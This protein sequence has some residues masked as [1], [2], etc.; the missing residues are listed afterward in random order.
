MNRRE[1]LQK[2]IEMDGA[3]PF[4]HFGLAMEWAKEGQVEES[5]QSFDRCTALDGHYT[6]AFYHKGK[7]LLDAGRLGEARAALKQGIVAA[8]AIANG[9][10]LSEMTELLESIPGA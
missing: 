8:Q 7:T 2:L 4:L 1:K 9:H 5:V 6:A 3:D 10:A